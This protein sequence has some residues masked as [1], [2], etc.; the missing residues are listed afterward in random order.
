MVVDPMH[1]APARRIAIGGAVAGA[2][3]ARAMETR[4]GAF[5]EP[6]RTG[7]G[8]RYGRLSKRLTLAGAAVLGL[9][10]RRRAGALVGGGLVLAGEACLPWSVFEGGFVSARDPR[11]TIEPQRERIGRGRVPA[12]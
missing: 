10:G 1:A 11:Y 9:A 5:G 7:A 4:L 6:Q 12:A 8:R 3:L 2:A